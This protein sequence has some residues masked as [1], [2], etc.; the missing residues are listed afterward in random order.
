[1][2][3]R[4]WG[5]AED[6]LIELLAERAPDGAGMRIEGLPGDRVRTAADRVRAALVNSGLLREVPSVTLRV[7]PPL[8]AGATSDLDLPLALA[9]LAHAGLVASGLRW[10]LATG[11]LGLDGTIHADDLTGP[12]TIVSVVTVLGR[13]AAVS[14]EHMFEKEAR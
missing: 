11:R 2:G 14:S 1:M 13:A 5:V 7:R 9:V 12:T 8:R 6:R 3:V 4:V 10:I